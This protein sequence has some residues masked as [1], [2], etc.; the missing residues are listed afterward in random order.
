VRTTKRQ[1]SE[2]SKIVK[3]GEDLAELCEVQY[4]VAG[5]SV[6]IFL[7]HVFDH[8]SRADE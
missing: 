8:D 2:E 1:V 3:Y 5:D 6:L 7:F 4:P